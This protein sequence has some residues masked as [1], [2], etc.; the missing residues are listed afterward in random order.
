MEESKSH[1]KFQFPEVSTFDICV[2]TGASHLLAYLLL[3]Y[4]HLCLLFWSLD[5]VTMR[6]FLV[7]ENTHLGVLRIY[8]V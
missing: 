4:D 6:S 2:C 7:S 8:C 1:L 5:I 3:R